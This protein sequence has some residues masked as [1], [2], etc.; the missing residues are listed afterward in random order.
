MQEV[1]DKAIQIDRAGSKIIEFLL[2]DENSLQYSYMEPVN[3]PEIV[4]VACWY[5]W[6]QQCQIM[7][8]EEVQC[9]VRTAPAI[10]ALALNFVRAVSKPTSGP[11]LNQ[12]RRP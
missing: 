11:R 5:L 7:R 10:H 4:S 1:I 9:P 2:C 12:W 6:W 8:E 3:Q